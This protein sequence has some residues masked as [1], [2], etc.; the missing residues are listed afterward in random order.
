MDLS[1]GA[2]TDSFQSF[3]SP[4]VLRAPRLAKQRCVIRFLTGTK[5]N[6]GITYPNAGVRLLMGNDE[7]ECAIRYISRANHDGSSR[8]EAGSVDTVCFDD[9]NLDDVS[10]L[11]ICPEEGEWDLHSVIL[12][13]G[14]SDPP[15]R[16]TNEG[17]IGTDQNPCAFLTPSYEKPYDEETRVRG[18]KK[19]DD[20]KRR[21]L[22]ID[23][24][25]TLFGTMLTYAS[26]SDIEMTKA[27]LE[28]G[29]VGI[30]YVFLLEKQID[31]MGS[32]DKALLFPLVSGPVRLFLISY[33]SVSSVGF[34]EQ[35]L[36]APFAL[37]F[38]MYK[39]AVIFAGMSK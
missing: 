15:I 17:Q 14:Q 33:L 39:L 11:W 31:F 6:S 20:M 23:L 8:F 9:V 10:Y 37:G 27:F 16:F 29:T 1:G 38:F 13:G 36:L 30:V 5:P 7:R 2:R 24:Y 35:R 34:S 28:G 3:T 19:Y 21:L 12:E 26:T 18:M 32:L 25:L 4:T 22:S